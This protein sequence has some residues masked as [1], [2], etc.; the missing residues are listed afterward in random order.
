[1][2]RWRHAVRGGS[3]SGHSTLAGFAASC[4]VHPVQRVPFVSTF[5]VRSKQCKFNVETHFL[6]HLS[7]KRTNANKSACFTNHVSLPV[8][9][10]LLQFKKAL[11]QY[12]VHKLNK[13]NIITV[14]SRGSHVFSDTDGTLPCDLITEEHACL[15]RLSV[16]PPT[17]TF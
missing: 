16:P 13:W 11:W 10:F 14:Y 15:S 4:R 7:W 17:T 8:P 12:N 5:N 2:T 9:T 1:M 3:P 6:L